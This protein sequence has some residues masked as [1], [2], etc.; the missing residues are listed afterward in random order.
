MI[1]RTLESAFLDF[2]RIIIRFKYFILI[3]SFASLIFSYYYISPSYYN[4]YYITSIEVSPVNKN[5]V[6]KVVNLI[7]TVDNKIRI[8]DAQLTR[9]LNLTLHGSNSVP[10]KLLFHAPTVFPKESDLFT[11]RR[12]DEI[13]TD[14]KHIKNRIEGM[15][16]NYFMSNI[17][18]GEI[19][20]KGLSKMQLIPTNLDDNQ[21]YDFISNFIN[22]TYGEQTVYQD[23]SSYTT[24]VENPNKPFKINLRYETKQDTK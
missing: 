24:R 6:N 8:M 17:R 14:I 1:D 15:A 11:Y 18:S 7:D 21:K 3:P 19:V 22:N 10:Y 13:T 23:T 5:A 9:V 20:S 2:I 16:L 12:A 4:P